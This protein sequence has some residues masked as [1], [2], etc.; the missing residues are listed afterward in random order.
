MPNWTRNELT[1]QADDPKDI[2]EFKEKVFTKDD[3]GNLQFDFEK[4]VPM[5]SHIFRGNLGDEERN[6]YGKHNWYD[7]SCENWGTKWNSCRTKI[8]FE[9]D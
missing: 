8:N 9:C 1:V 7:W 2:K 4:I 3:E 6:K 5:P